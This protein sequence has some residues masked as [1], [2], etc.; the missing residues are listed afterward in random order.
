MTGRRI[1]QS[2]VSSCLAHQKPSSIY[3]LRISRRC[4]TIRVRSSEI[5]SS[6]VLGPEDSAFRYSYIVVMYPYLLSRPIC[7]VGRSELGFL[8]LSQR[9]D[10]RLYIRTARRIISRIDLCAVLMYRVCSHIPDACCQEE[11]PNEKIASICMVD[12]AGGYLGSRGGEQGSGQQG[13]HTLSSNDTTSIRGWQ[14]F[15]FG[16]F[17]VRTVQS[18]SMVCNLSCGRC[19]MDTTKLALMIG[20]AG[21]DERPPEDELE[22]FN[23]CIVTRK[24]PGGIQ[25]RPR[26]GKLAE[27]REDDNA[28]SSSSTRYSMIYKNKGGIQPGIHPRTYGILM[29]KKR[30]LGRGWVFFW[31]MAGGRL[32]LLADTLPVL[33]MF[34]GF[35]E[36]TSPSI[37]PVGHTY[38]TGHLLQLTVIERSMVSAQGMSLFWGKK[39]LNDTASNCQVGSKV[40]SEAPREGGGGGYFGSDTWRE[41]ANVLLR[42][43]STYQLETYS[44]R[45]RGL[46]RTH[47]ER[48]PGR[49]PKELGGKKGGGGGHGSI[50]RI[51]RREIKPG[52]DSSKFMFPVDKEG[53]TNARQAQ[54]SIEISV[55]CLH[56]LESPQALTIQSNPMRHDT[57]HV[58]GLLLK[59]VLSAHAHGK[60]AIE[61]H[62]KKADRQTLLPWLSTA[63]RTVLKK[64][65]GLFA[66]AF[67]S[68]KS[69]NVPSLFLRLFYTIEGRVS[70]E[71]WISTH[72]TVKADDEIN[73]VSQGEHGSALTMLCLFLSPV[74]LYFLSPSDTAR[75]LTS[76]TVVEE[77]PYSKVAAIPGAP[78]VER[79]MKKGFAKGRRE[80]CILFRTAFLRRTDVNGLLVRITSPFSPIPSRVVLFPSTHHRLLNRVPQV[81]LKG[82]V[83]AA[84]PVYIERRVSEAGALPQN[85][86]NCPWK[87]GRN[88]AVVVSSRGLFPSLSFFCAVLGLKFPSLSEFPTFCL[89]PLTSS[90]SIE[91]CPLVHLRHQ[92]AA[93]LFF[94]GTADSDSTKIPSPRI[95]SGKSSDIYYLSPKVD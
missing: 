19:D 92:S 30:E 86:L 52:Q 85:F 17:S 58:P 5:L 35:G 23:R 67:T 37:V 48:Q 42:T 29:M 63:W 10:H 16:G 13:T 26:Y 89:P 32:L 91:P 28:V 3:L 75:R 2:S 66:V 6:S 65:T 56:S 51:R 22:R 49:G 73:T 38:L 57:T 60:L 14:S 70:L 41:W 55:L 54:I 83:S 72:I 7:R 77:V 90:L 33:R 9:A 61:R 62:G 95:K 71:D 94:D 84:R 4:Q 47:E 24:Q 78:Q 27:P 39:P 59:C 88:M 74:N 40:T 25:G 18:S 79:K 87:S 31:G 50:G 64:R 45:T 36:G 68:L 11:F 43:Q 76:C 1:I 82:L 12:A 69:L 53:A 8:F 21:V 93:Y 15:T 34:L 44:Y 20:L 80:P 46:G 81:F